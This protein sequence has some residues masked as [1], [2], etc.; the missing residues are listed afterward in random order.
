MPEWNPKL[1]EEEQLLR[2][3]V[4]SVALSHQE[5]CVCLTCKAAAGDES[6]FTKLAGA[7]RDNGTKLTRKT[8]R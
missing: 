1:F 6:A 7:L 2:G 8:R 3:S 4:A 5:N